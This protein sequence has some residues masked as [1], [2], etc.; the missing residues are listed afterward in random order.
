MIIRYTGKN[1]ADLA[2]EEAQQRIAKSG[3][4]S[5]LSSNLIAGKEYS[6]FA[7]S[8]WSDGGMRVYIH[9]LEECSFPSPFPLELFEIVDSVIC[10]NW[11][12]SRMSDSTTG[13]DF[14][15][16]FKEWALDE[17]F[18]ERLLDGDPECTAVY[19]KYLDESQPN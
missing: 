13:K 6:I 19:E 17:T 3:D 16:S 2:S 9:S 8:R 5:D 15:F 18:Y 4:F 14:V 11:V 7:L 12:T 1:I 10:E